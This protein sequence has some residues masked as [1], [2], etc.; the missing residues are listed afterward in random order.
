MNRVY[1]SILSTAADLGEV[2]PAAGRLIVCASGCAASSVPV[3]AEALPALLLGAARRPL[4]DPPQLAAAS[5]PFS[6][7]RGE[8]QR[9]LFFRRVG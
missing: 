3:V 7:G 8:W 2:V 4:R 5:C 1:G 9:G 6:A